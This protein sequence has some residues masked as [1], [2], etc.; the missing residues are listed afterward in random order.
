VTTISTPIII[1][2]GVCYKCIAKLN[3]ILALVVIFIC[4]IVKKKFN[5]L[6]CF[7]HSLITWL[8]RFIYLVTSGHLPF[9]HAVVSGLTLWKG[10]TRLNNL[11]FD[12]F[13]SNNVYDIAAIAKKRDSKYFFSMTNT[14]TNTIFAFGD[15][16]GLIYFCRACT[17]LMLDFVVLANSNKTICVLSQ[18]AVLGFRHLTQKTW[19]RFC[20]SLISFIVEKLRKSVLIHKMIYISAASG[21]NVHFRCKRGSRLGGEQRWRTGC[22]LHVQEREPDHIYCQTRRLLSGGRRLRSPPALAAGVLHH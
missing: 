21:T 7:S 9:S 1:K 12:G 11:W 15:G 2:R 13:Y 3:F 5:N 10:P 16:V 6:Y 8:W 22:R 4:D 19:H 18:Y 14:F 20:C 17:Y